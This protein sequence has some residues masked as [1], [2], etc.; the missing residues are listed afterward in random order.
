MH[1]PG[2]YTIRVQLIAGMV[3][4]NLIHEISDVG[5]DYHMSPVDVANGVVDGHM[6]LY[7][8]TKTVNVRR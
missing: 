8:R 2:R 1:G 3:P 6:V 4:V 7:D 5:F